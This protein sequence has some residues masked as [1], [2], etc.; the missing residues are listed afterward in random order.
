MNTA[1]IAKR[2]AISL[3]QLGAA[4]SQIDTF[5][6][7]LS[8]ID[9]LFLATPEIPAAFADPAVS[10]QHKKELMGTIIATCGCSV[11]ISNFLQ[12]LVDKSRTAI[13]SQIIHTFHTLADHHSG[14]LRPGITTAFAL[15]DTQ[16]T[17]VREALEKTSAKRVIPQVTVD[18]SLLGGIVVRIGDTV[19]DSSIK[20]QLSRIQEHLQKG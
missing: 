3:V 17:K 5:R 10:Q 6:R 14:I 20:T 4:E 15:D 1:T 12:L 11:L 18:N 16:L 9:A 7:E 8:R 13:L 19:Y 2:Y